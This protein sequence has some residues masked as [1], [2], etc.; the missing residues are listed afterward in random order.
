MMKKYEPSADSQYQ[1]Y[2]WHCYWLPLRNSASW[3]VHSFWDY[4]KNS[5]ISTD[6]SVLSDNPQ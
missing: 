6:N 2:F 1:F 5:N 3:L 4:S